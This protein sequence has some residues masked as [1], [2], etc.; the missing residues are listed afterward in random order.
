MFFFEIFYIFAKKAE[1]IIKNSFII[2]KN[3][4]NDRRNRYKRR[5]I[6]AKKL[7]IIN[8]DF[9]HKPERF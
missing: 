9:G 2:E 5:G 7:Q 8:T 3:V 6:K 1:N 4:Q